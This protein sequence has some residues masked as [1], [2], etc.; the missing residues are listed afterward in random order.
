MT[1]PRGNSFKNILSSAS[2]H[3]TASDPQFS[4]IGFTGVNVLAPTINK[5]STGNNGFTV[6][7][8]THAHIF[9]ESVQ[10]QNPEILKKTL[11]AL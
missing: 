5:Q 2:K 9:N 6:T 4:K 10:L 7:S 1:G 3:K 11:I 8:G